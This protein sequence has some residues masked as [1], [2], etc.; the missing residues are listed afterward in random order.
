ME[1]QPY[2]YPALKNNKDKVLNE[3]EKDVR[4]AIREVARR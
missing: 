4:K 1:A 3:I 2:L